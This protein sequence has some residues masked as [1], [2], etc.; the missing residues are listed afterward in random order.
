MCLIGDP[1]SD[2]VAGCFGKQHPGEPSDGNRLC[3]SAAPATPLRDHW[4]I[5]R[6]RPLRVISLGGAAQVKRQRA[7]VI[8]SERSAGMAD[9]QRST[10]R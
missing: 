9:R 1:L 4:A 6:L 5:A 10:P 2:L 8:R 3:R 7:D